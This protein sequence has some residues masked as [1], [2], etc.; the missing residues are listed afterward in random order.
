[1]EN[2]TKSF[3]FKKF[4]ISPIGKFAM[5]AV[6]YF[7]IMGLIY[8]ILTVFEGAP[9]VAVIMAVILSYFGW[10]ALTKITP[11]VFLILPVGGWIAYYVI[12]GFLSFFLGV[13]VA[14]FVISKKIVKAVTSSVE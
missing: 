7:V 10:Q 13:F 9:I 2:E 3:D 12:K 4:L 1:M 5:I 14:P 11:N 6:L 8:L